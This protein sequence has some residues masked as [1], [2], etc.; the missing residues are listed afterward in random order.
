MDFRDSFRGELEVLIES[1]KDGLFVGHDQHFNKVVVES[2][3][4]LL[5]NWINI[6]NYEVRGEFNYAKL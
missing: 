6:D 2:D 3:E 4:D 1:E 5:G